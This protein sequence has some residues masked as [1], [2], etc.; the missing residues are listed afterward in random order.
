MVGRRSVGR[1]VAVRVAGVVP[2]GAGRQLA[3]AAGAEARGTGADV[4]QRLPDGARRR[5]QLRAGRSLGGV[6]P[7]GR[8]GRETRRD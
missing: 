6:L 3:R 5:R 4:G 7:A 1:H 2:R 8:V